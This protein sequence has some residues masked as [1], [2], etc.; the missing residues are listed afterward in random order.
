MKTTSDEITLSVYSGPMD[1]PTVPKIATPPGAA[2]TTARAMSSTTKASYTPTSTDS[3][4]LTIELGDPKDST[5]P[6]K[7]KKSKNNSDDAPLSRLFAQSRPEWAAIFFA[8]LLSIPAEGAGLLM[9]LIL[10]KAYDAIVDPSLSASGKKDVV[11]VRRFLQLALAT[12]ESDFCELHHAPKLTRLISTI[13][14]FS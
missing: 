8:F 6:T 9:P 12:G 13:S 10:A 5:T 2:A 7:K 14:L 4:V 11:T 1:L 3:E